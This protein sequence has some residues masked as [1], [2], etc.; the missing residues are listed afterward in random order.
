MKLGCVI[1]FSIPY[2]ITTPSKTAAPIGANPAKCMETFLQIILILNIC[3]ELLKY[4]IKDPV[5][6]PAQW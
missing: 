3:W 4:T 6:N 2:F 5:T 1:N